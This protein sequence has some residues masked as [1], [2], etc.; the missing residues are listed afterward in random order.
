MKNDYELL[1]LIQ[2]E[3]DQIALNYMFNKYEGFIWKQIHLLH[4]N[5]SEHEDF[6]QEGRMMF[7]KAI[8]TFHERFNKTFT[9]YFELILKRHFYRLNKKVPKYVFDEYVINTYQYGYIEE[10]YDDFLTL[11]S[12]FEQRVFRYYFLENKTVKYIESVEKC[13]VKQIYNAIYRLKEKYK[14]YDII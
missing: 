3:N 1:Y 12:S 8:N 14:K 4:V 13:S 5:Q 9:R 7:I 11:C 6:M 10:D 2:G